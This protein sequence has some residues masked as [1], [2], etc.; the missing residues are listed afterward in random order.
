MPQAPVCHPGLHQNS[1]KRIHIS[2]RRPTLAPLLI[3]SVF[4][5]KLNKK[6]MHRTFLVNSFYVRLRGAFPPSP[7]SSSGLDSAPF[8]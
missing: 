1:W 7:I 2:A 4:G 6:M 8:S 5:E 3:Q